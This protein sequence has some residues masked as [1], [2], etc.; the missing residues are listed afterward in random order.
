MRGR[1]SLL[2]VFTVM[3]VVV[4]GVL[5][6]A[7]SEPIVLR[8][9]THINEPTLVDAQISLMREFE[10]LHPGVVVEVWY[11]DSN[12]YPDQLLAQYLGGIGP[13]VATLLR[14]QFASFID[15]GL[16]QSLEPYIAQDASFSMDLVVPSLMNSGL[17]KGEVYGFPVYNGPA[18]LFY[19]QNVFI[20]RGIAEP[21]AYIAQGTWNWDTFVDVAKKLTYDTSGDERPDVCGY[22]GY[23]AAWEAGWVPYIRAAGGDV[24]GPDGRSALNRPESIMGLEFL[25]NLNVEHRVTRNPGHG[26]C[27]Y[28]VGGTA[29][30]IRWQTTALIE[31]RLIT[32][33]NLEA[34]LNP[35]GPAG[36]AH[37]AGG[38]PVTVSRH[39][40]YPELAYEYAK[41][42]ALES[43]LW[44]IR[45]GPPLTF[46]EL[47]SAEYRST[48]EEFEHWIL[49]ER[50]IIEGDTR[51]EPQFGIVQRDAM[52]RILHGELITPVINGEKPVRTAMEEAH[53]LLNNLLEQ[54]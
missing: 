44:T 41:W 25:N 33:F 39:T 36:Y 51:P 47:R 5:A 34:A 53:R 54:E 32:T 10:K 29:M 17:Y 49:F 28:A 3:L 20:D 35:A 8:V 11:T 21:S 14:P 26:G 46:E 37:L 52:N 1:Q 7:Q 48:L 42:L 38:V 19:N 2:I 30:R 31:K 15:A 4:G 50:A 16:I 45:G 9:A 22:D 18:Q 27:S 24:I 6:A 40:Q 13:D 12:N 23:E 43:G